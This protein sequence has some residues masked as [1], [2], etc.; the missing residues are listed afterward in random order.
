LHI[1]VKHPLLYQVNT[2]VMLTEIGSVRGR[3]ATLDD[4]PEATLDAWASDGFALIWL[5]GVWQ[6]GDAGRR[7][8]RGTVARNPE[9]RTDL[10]GY[11]EADVVSSPFAV[12]EYHVHQDFGGD[13]ALARLRERLTCRGQR[14]ILDFVANHV[15]PDHPW[16]EEHPEFFIEGSPDDLAREP[17]NFVRLEVAGGKRI[18]AHGRDPFFPGWDD[19]LQL[20][21]QHAGCREML[22]RELLRVS[23]RCDG[24]RCDMAM[25]LEPEVFQRTWGPQAAPPDGSAPVTTA[26]WSSAIQ[27][28]RELR[29]DFLFMAEVYWDMEWRLQQEGFDFTYD[30]RL[31]D[32]LLEGTGQPVREHLRATAD[33]QNHSARFLENHDEPRAA[34]VFP[35]DRHRAAAVIAFLVPGLR[36]FHEGQLEGR[37]WH[38]PMQ[39]RRRP[40]EAPDEGLES[41]YRRLLELIRRPETHQ[42]TW[43]LREPS[44]AWEGNETW[45]NFVAFTWEMD[46]QSLLAA[47]NYGPTQGQCYLKLDLP[48]TTSACILTDL[49]GE[50]RY[51]RAGADLRERGLYLDLPAWGYHVFMVARSSTSGC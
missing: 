48:A 36:F 47:V 15:A 46:G 43:R 22:I 11:A 33:F 35:A 29:K 6:T 7:L 51:Q 50:A 41:F 25:L 39:L 13:E 26:F 30:K 31:Y 27:R 21:L 9:W 24:V 16:V 23:G 18:L 3:G 40:S 10:P 4:L 28:T 34:K 45:G 2:R 49:M 32:R 12:R 8:A 37:R 1:P 44:A 14:L 5:L 38:V 19:T 42:G 20:N 17:R